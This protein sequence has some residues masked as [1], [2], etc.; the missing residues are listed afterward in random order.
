[1]QMNKNRNIRKDKL[2]GQLMYQ[3]YSRCIAEI[4]ER[5]H[6]KI[7]ARNY[8]TAEVASVALDREEI[9]QGINYKKVVIFL[10]SNGCEWA[11]SD[12]H[13]CTMCG[14]LA[15]QTR[16][17][18]LISANDHISQFEREF[19]RID[20]KKYPLL[21]IF[22]NGS[23]LNENEI[24]PHARWEILKII[25]HNPDIKMLVVE[26][27]PEYVNES[28]V[29]EI[30]KLL[31]NKYVE[32]AMGLELKDDIYRSICFNKGFSLQD[33]NDAASIIAK[34]LHLRTY[35]FLK[36]PFLTERESIEQAIKTVDHAFSVGS[37]TVS[38]EAGTIQ[39]FTLAKH[40]YKQGLY[41]P[42]WLWSIG[43]VVKK[44][45]EYN[46]L[47]VGLFKFYP[48]P[49][50]VPYNCP[51]CS[52]A[53]IGAIRSYNKTLKADVFNGLHC[54]C[55]AKWQEVLNETPLA[56]E[57]RLEMALTKLKNSVGMTNDQ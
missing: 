16:K 49:T 4:Q 22:N 37:S 48:S 3:K 28:S 34:H 38:L 26:S 18:K 53:V 54:R 30:K 9:F 24:A 42:P 35:V 13:G 50:A 45:R 11:L 51:D 2:T 27:R 46:N 33:Y 44:C 20:F 25:N 5:I 14:H 31:S 29:K 12:A 55:K 52:D 6:A 15:K 40:L 23:F 17:N 10:M 1:M 43:E 19:K 41:T 8:N 36:P 21:N 7:P 47:I 56:F 32:I 39:N 57:V